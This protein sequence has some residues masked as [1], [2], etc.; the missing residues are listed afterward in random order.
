M[1]FRHKSAFDRVSH[2]KLFLKLIRRGVPINL[3]F[4]LRSWY[5]HQKLRVIWGSVKSSAFGM[6]NGIRQGSIISPYLFNVYVDDLNK[7][8]NDSGLGCY[9]GEKPSNNFS[10]ADDIALL[11]PSAR[12]L[13]SMLAICAEFARVNLMEFSPSKSVVLLIL[14]RRYHISRPPNIY[15]NGSLLSYVDQFKYLGHFI[16]ADFADDLDIDRERRSLAARGNILLRK[17]GQCSY[18]VKCMLFKTYCYQ[19]YSCSLWARYKKSSINRLRVCFNTILRRL[20]GLPQWSSASN[21]FVE[22]RMRS[23]QEVRRQLSYSL[24]M[25]VNSSENLLLCSIVNSDAAVFSSIR[26]H[27]NNLLVI[28]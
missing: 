24:M 13:N 12:A 20:L 6:S 16:T 7:M 14:P 27:W 11:A 28:R 19:L 1:F 5:S 4:F 8:L 21:M 15:L 26:E 9:V 10:Y 22:M 18:E 23:L 17:F 2:S 25:R 3:V